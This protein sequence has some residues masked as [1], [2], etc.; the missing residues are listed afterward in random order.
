MKQIEVSL[1]VRVERVDILP[2]YLQLFYILFLAY[3]VSR[4]RE[5]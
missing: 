3:G 1:I 2:Y 5:R 4:R